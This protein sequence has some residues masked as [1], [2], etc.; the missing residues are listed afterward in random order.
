MQARTNCDA[1]IFPFPEY[2]FG[3]INRFLPAV[4]SANLIPRYSDTPNDDFAACPSTR[5]L[6][7]FTSCPGIHWAWT[8]SWN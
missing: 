1:V 3:G 2:L 8:K 5:P 6:E 4:D 7:V